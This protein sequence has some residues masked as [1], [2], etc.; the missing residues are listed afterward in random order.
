MQNFIKKEGFE[1]AFDQ[2]ACYTCNGACCRGQSGYIWLNKKEMIAI[3][4]FLGIKVEELKKDYLKKEGYRYSI[5][6]IAKN[7]EH[8][9]LFFDEKNNRC[10]IY[11]VRPTQC[12]TFPFWERYKDKK[13]IEEVCQECK[14]IYP[15][16]S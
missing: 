6:E 10:E 13:N 1:F 16:S 4:E 9:C 7:A 2:N 3:A 8:L 12:R 14:G 15:F 11:P 5:K